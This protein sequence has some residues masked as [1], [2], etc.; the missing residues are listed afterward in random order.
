MITVFVPVELEDGTTVIGES[1]IGGRGSIKRVFLQ[2]RNVIANDEA[3]SALLAADI[4]VIG[5]GSVYTSILPNLLVGELSR[6][7][8]ASQAV[9][10]YV[11]NVA[12]EPGETD[13]FSTED[14]VRVL[15]N[16]VAPGLFQFVLANSYTGAEMPNHRR[17][18]TFVQA[19][20]KDQATL[21]SQGLEVITTD[22]L[23]H[24]EPE[25]HDPTRL[26]NAI[27]EIHASASGSSQILAF[28]RLDQTRNQS[29]IDR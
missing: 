23:N 4:I 28:S 3:V 7:I 5:P 15:H 19:S 24:A 13:R 20:A 6:A 2:P 8:R 22:V 21:G 10:I 17:A 27:M 25:H 12:T 29:G 14:H 16:H 26:A 9:K 11:C 18:A 1:R